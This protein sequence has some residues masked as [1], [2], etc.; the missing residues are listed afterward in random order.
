MKYTFLIVVVSF[1]IL[2]FSGCE[3]EFDYDL[4][5]TTWH[6]LVY[7]EILV[8]GEE[9]E[10]DYWQGRAGLEPDVY[11][12]FNSDG[13]T[14]WGGTWEKTDELTFKWTCTLEDE[15][16]E[17][18]TIYHAQFNDNLKELGGWSTSTYGRESFSQSPYGI[19]GYFNATK[20][21]E[22]FY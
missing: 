2:T 10:D 7:W 11:I 20:E 17:Y 9:P 4:N 16:G 15:A 5:D 8:A 22:E 3:E 13:T 21:E 14:S 6:I 1:L 12:T 18:T 19:T